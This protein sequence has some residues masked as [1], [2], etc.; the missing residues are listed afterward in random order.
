MYIGNI[1]QYIKF[2]Q[3]GKLYIT[4]GNLEISENKFAFN[5][6]ANS[7]FIIGEQGLKY[8]LKGTTLLELGAQNIIQSS[9]FKK[10]T[11]TTAGTGMQI[12]LGS[13]TITS[14][15]FAL[16]SNA[17][18]VDTNFFQLNTAN[19]KLNTNPANGDYWFYV[20]DE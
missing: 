7:N 2:T 18:K 5:Y 16:D 12:N 19:L 3:G 9:N 14:Y 13:G 1:G 8:V 17:L 4:A 11:S 6:S 15:D 10:T 20:G